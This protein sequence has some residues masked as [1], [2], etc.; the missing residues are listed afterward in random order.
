MGDVK[1][2]KILWVVKTSVLGSSQT[3]DDVGH[4]SARA[5]KAL[6]FSG[7]CLLYSFFFGLENTFISLDLVSMETTL[8]QQSKYIIFSFVTGVQYSGSQFLKVILLFIV[9]IKYWLYSLCCT[10]YPCS[11]FYTQQFEPHKP[12]PLYC[13]SPLP[14]LHW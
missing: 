1:R 2:H 7:W 14:S 4:P 10:I 6:V 9:I 11:L 13:P 5:A 8:Y 3:Q 12:L